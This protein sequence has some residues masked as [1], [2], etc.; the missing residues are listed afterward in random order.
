M[1]IVFL[2]LEETVIDDIDSATILVNRC[3]QI[4]KVLNHIRPDKI[5][6]FSWAIRD[7]SERKAFLNSCTKSRIEDH[8]GHQ[9]DHDLIWTLE[10]VRDDIFKISG[11]QLFVDDIFDI[12]GKEECLNF[13]FRK[14][15]FKKDVVLIDDTVS[16]KHVTEFDGLRLVYLNAKLLG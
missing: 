14:H 15:F 4:R 12:F 6:V 16:H 1:T 11:K 13:L 8:I 5:G 3:E 7:E 10:S 9:F 2:D